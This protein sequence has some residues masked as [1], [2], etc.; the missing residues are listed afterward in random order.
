[1]PNVVLKVRLQSG[2]LEVDESGHANHIGRGEATI[3]WRLRRSCPNRGSFNALD[4]PAHPGFA[5]IPPL[6]P[7]GVFG[8]P[9]L[10]NSGDRITI[11][12]TNDV[13][14]SSGEWAYRLCVTINSLPYSTT[15]IVPTNT[16]DPKIKNL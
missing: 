5:W 11:S 3:T 16:T 13:A 12:D 2:L 4:D 8:Q 10:A 1:M 9:R 6:P 7:R 14:S 15:G